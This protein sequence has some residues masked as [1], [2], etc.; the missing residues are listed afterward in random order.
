MEKWMNM[1]GQHLS[2]LTQHFNHYIGIGSIPNSVVS[3]L[4]QHKDLGV[5]TEMFSDGVVDLVERG[6][7][8]NAQKNLRPGKLVSSFAMGSRRLFRFLDNNPSVGA[9]FVRH[10]TVI[11]LRIDSVKF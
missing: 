6:C 3:C 11:P 4:H 1:Q 10:L 7:I 8:T 2:T 9:S 5:H